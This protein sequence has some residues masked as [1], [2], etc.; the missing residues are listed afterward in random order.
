MSNDGNK[1][2]RNK[3]PSPRLHRITQKWS[4]DEWRLFVAFA[5]VYGNNSKNLRLLE[6]VRSMGAVYK[7]ALEKEAFPGTN[8]A[9]IRFKAIRYSYNTGRRLDL[10]RDYDLVQAHGNIQLAIQKCSFDDAHEF[11]SEAMEMALVTEDFVMAAMFLV[12]ER[13]IIM[14]SLIGEK[15]TLAMQENAKTA[16]GNIANLALATEIVATRALYLEAPRNLYL[17]T[18]ARDVPAIHAYFNS[19]IGTRSLTAFPASLQIE[20]LLLDELA[21]FLLGNIQAATMAAE[22]ILTILGAHEAMRK[23]FR[24]THSKSLSNLASHYADTG[25][26][27]QAKGVI[28]RFQAIVPDS[29]TNRDCYLSDYIYVLF[30]LAIDLK[31]FSIGRKGLV[32]HFRSFC[33]I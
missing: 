18:G 23:R 5:K 31:D 12:Q 2:S 4:E 16:M 22:E 8:L 14:S 11:L 25:K 3:P 15:R 10:I 33:T 28:L 9:T 24:T 32:Q 21:H 26:V 20:R 1:K 30:Q 27:E 13:T 6:L 17:S 19:E 7:P 29:D